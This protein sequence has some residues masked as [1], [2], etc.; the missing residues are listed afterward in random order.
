MLG[1]EY[2]ATSAYR[3]KKAAEAGRSAALTPEDVAALEAQRTAEA[4]PKMDAALRKAD[5][6][7]RA[8][9]S[10]AGKA[11][12]KDTS[13][14]SLLQDIGKM[15]TFGQQS[16]NRF[17]A[18]A[19]GWLSNADRAAEASG[20]VQDMTG[21][22]RGLKDDALNYRKQLAALNDRGLK[23]IKVGEIVSDISGMLKQPAIAASES[24]PA[25]QVVMQRIASTGGDPNALYT[26]KKELS[27]IVKN[28]IKAADP[29]T[30]SKIAASVTARITPM[31]DDAIDKASGGTWKE[32]LT[33]YRD[34]SRKM[35]QANVMSRLQTSLTAPLEGAAER[36]VPFANAL[37]NQDN[38]ISK[39]TGQKRY[40]SLDELMTK[41]QLEAIGKVKN[42]LDIESKTKDAASAGTAQLRNTLKDLQHM[43]GVNLL[44]RTIYI[45]Q[46]IMRRAK[47]GASE[48][49]L[50]AL[51][52]KMNDPQVIAKLMTYADAD[53]RRELAKYMTM[54]KGVSSGA[55]AANRMGA[56]Q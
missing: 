8:E 40:E 21:L 5:I 27:D 16:T 11:E 38:L 17:E 28:T 33:T 31:I 32:Y 49:T 53:E 25:L 50:Q 10:L 15:A 39:S 52:T 26:V 9:Q 55:I 30:A 19:P 42:Q 18:G 35:D 29:G 51:A 54:L 14:V 41:E 36:R 13:A 43:E 6:V 12:A 48:K 45:V 3:A 7:T 46:S 24:A 23:G 4:L 2:G 44:D 56:A 1:E 34:I 20:A 47:T 37:N 22:W